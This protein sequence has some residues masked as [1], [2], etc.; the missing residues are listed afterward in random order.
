VIR[1]PSVASEPDS[2]RVPCQGSEPNAN[3]APITNSGHHALLQRG[4]V[5]AWYSPRIESAEHFLGIA[6]DSDLAT[7]SS[8]NGMDLLL[9]FGQPPV[10]SLQF[11]PE[12]APFVDNNQVRTTRYYTFGGASARDRA[13]ISCVLDREPNDMFGREMSGTGQLEGEQG[14]DLFRQRKFSDNR[15]R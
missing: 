7:G 11:D 6:R 3:R 15:R 1:V 2:K 5:R 9:C 12:A 13:G 14:G 10:R 8:Q 4:A